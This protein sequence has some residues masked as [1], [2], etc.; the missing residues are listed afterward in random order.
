[1]PSMQIVVQDEMTDSQLNS[2][3]GGWEDGMSV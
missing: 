3:V 2:C 1:M